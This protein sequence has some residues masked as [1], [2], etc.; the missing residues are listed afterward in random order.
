[1][2]EKGVYARIFGIHDSK[3]VDDAGIITAIIAWYLHPVE[4]V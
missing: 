3:L 1:M 4:V 2:T